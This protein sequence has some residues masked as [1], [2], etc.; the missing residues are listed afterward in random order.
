M[1]RPL[2][3]LPFP[4]YQKEQSN[5]LLRVPFLQRLVHISNLPPYSGIEFA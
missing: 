2:E 1:G 3:E 4:V 5:L